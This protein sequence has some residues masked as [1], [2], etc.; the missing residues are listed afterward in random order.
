MGYN[1][2]LQFK[3]KN[4]ETHVITLDDLKRRGSELN[5]PRL[6]E[7]RIEFIHGDIRNREYLEG[8]RNTD[9]IIEC[10]ADIL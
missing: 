8:T 6:K 10:S 9:L 7:K 1:L 4:P 2:A 5:L 3:K